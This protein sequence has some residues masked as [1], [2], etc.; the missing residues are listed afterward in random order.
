MLSRRTFL[1][2]AGA[3]FSGAVVAPVSGNLFIDT[4][5]QLELSQT[6]IRLKDLPPAFDGFRIAFLSDPHVGDCSSS[7]LL[8]QAVQ[9]CIENK[10]DLVILGGDYI[11]SL[12]LRQNRFFYYL[13]NRNSLTS[14]QK[15]PPSFRNSQELGKY[16]FDLVARIVSKI[17]PA[18]GIVAILGNHDR[19]NSASN[20][21]ELFRQHGIIA[22]VNQSVSLH[23]NSQNFEIYGSDDYTTGLPEAPPRSESF[24]LLLSHNPDFLE[25]ISNSSNFSLGLAGHTHGGQICLPVIGALFPNIQ[26]TEL[27]QGVRQT[28]C[29]QTAFISRGIGTSGLPWR[30]NCKAEVALITLIQA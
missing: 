22:L 1:L 12:D 24:R 7:E 18:E 2:S 27:I 14:C 21:L 15:Y 3:A 4:T 30:I 13:K 6:I 17:N 9:F 19:W 11:N 10:P 25:E 29:G 23:R 28:S 26:H 5:N 16:Y 20:C 8:E